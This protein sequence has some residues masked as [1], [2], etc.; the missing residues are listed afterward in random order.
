MESL[1]VEREVTVYAI[2]ES[3]VEQISSFNTLGSVFVGIG[4][5]MLSYA[6]GIWTNASFVEKLTPMG[7]VASAFLALAVVMGATNGGVNDY[8]QL[9]S[10]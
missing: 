1:Y 7:D 10:G 2:H 4:A 5:A 8:V 6:I 3:E 9:G